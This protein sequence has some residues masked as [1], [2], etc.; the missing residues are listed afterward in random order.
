MNSARP[1][2]TAPATYHAIRV[3]YRSRHDYQVLFNVAEQLRAEV[4]QNVSIDF[5]VTSN[6]TLQFGA[7]RLFPVWPSYG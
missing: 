6:Y 2:L 3:G 5:E 7:C 1:T 4:L